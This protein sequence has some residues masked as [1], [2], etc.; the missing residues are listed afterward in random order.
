[1][2]FEEDFA[3][4]ELVEFEIEKRNF[5]YRPTTAGDENNWLNEYMDV[6]EDGK[7]KP[8]LQ[9]INMCK[10]RN[11]IEVPYSKELIN[12]KIQVD[13]EWKNLTN[14]EKWKFLSKLTPSM[15][16]KIIKKINEIDAPESD[17]KKN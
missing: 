1:M 2:E 16:D 17:V 3:N 4:E 13:K 7:P 11:L 14:D 8:N 9:K 5:K 6:G 10:I 15:F 12:S